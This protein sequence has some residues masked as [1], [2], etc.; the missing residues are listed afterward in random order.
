MTPLDMARNLAASDRA[1]D[2]ALGVAIVARGLSDDDGTRAG[3]PLAAAIPAAAQYLGLP[4]DPSLMAEAG[5]LA[6]TVSD[7]MLNK[8][9]R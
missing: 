7:A 8:V 9:S 6:P 1:E 3:W 2:R 4:M 5:R